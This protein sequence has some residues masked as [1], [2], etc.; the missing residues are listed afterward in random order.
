MG[1]FAA[2]AG[3]ALTPSSANPPSIARVPVASPQGCNNACVKSAYLKVSIKK[4]KKKYNTIYCMIPIW[5]TKKK[6][7]IYIYIY[8]HTHTYRHYAASYQEMSIC[9]Y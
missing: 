1:G 9:T 7:I 6:K 8:T 3:L 4:E 5:W 2:R